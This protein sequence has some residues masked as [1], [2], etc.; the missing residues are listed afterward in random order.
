MLPIFVEED[1]NLQQDCMCHSLTCQNCDSLASPRLPGM[2]ALNSKICRSTG[3]EGDAG[4]A[5]EHL[6]GYPANKACIN[7]ASMHLVFQLT[8][9]GLRGL[10]VANVCM[11][12]HT[13]CTSSAA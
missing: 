1:P 8:M 4:S 6:A 7:M 9:T 13:V 2:H 3:T 12:L 5:Y 11:R 10:L